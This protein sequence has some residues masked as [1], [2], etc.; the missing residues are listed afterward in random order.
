MSMID[1][2]TIDIFHIK[3]VILECDRNEVEET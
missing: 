1:W 3:K 2:K